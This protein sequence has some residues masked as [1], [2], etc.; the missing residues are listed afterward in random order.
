[1]LDYKSVIFQGVKK[2]MSS[3]FNFSNSESNNPKGITD[4]NQENFNKINNPNLLLLNQV[5]QVLDNKQNNFQ[6]SNLSNNTGNSRAV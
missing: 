1:M 5:I 6:L 3:F 4:I 2:Y